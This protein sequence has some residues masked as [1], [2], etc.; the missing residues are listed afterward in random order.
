MDRSTIDYYEENAEKLAESCE[1]ADIKV[2][3]GLLLRF[4]P[5]RESVLE[6]G[7]GSLTTLYT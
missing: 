4:L 6:I 1:T 2:V 7:C 5:E 3:H